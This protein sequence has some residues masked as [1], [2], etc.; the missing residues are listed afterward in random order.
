[1]DE[2]VFL[3]AWIFEEEEEDEDEEKGGGKTTGSEREATGYSERSSGKTG[4]RKKRRC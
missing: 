2:V 3:D 1:M 4:R